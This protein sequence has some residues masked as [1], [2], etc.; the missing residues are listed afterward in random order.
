MTRLLLLSF[1]RVGKGTYWRALGFAQELVHL[2]YEVTLL[3]VAARRRWGFARQEINGVQVVESPDLMPRSGYDPWD[4]VNRL[5]WVRKRPFDLVHAFETRPVNI[6]PALLAQRRYK[7]PFVTDWCDWFGRGGSVEQRSNPLLRTILRPVETFFEEQFRPGAAG[8]TVINQT[9][10][11]KAHDLGIPAH[12]LLLLP[13]GANVTTI[14]PQDKTAVRAKLGLPAAAF[15]LGYTGAMFDDDALLM[16][17][18]FDQIQA[19]IP[20]ARLLLI[21]YTNVALEEMV[22][23][24]TAVW[25]TGPVNNQALADYVAAC[26]VGW[27]PLADIPA[28]QGRFPMKVHDFMAAGRPLLVSDL[29]DLGH[30][31]SQRNIGCAARSEPEAQA[32]QLMAMY[33]QPAALFT[34][35]VQARQTA[36]DEFAWSVVTAKL[37]RFYQQ[38]L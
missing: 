38:L 1:N 26:D 29:G 34:W 16:A 24:K 20:Q 31:V 21:G 15:V 12:G 35:G 32:Q 18:A 2:N 33:E 11:Q 14:R 9:L 19:A 22:R 28:N 3:A 8:T 27:L 25:R 36:T 6:F 7:V 17:A 5:A 37:D 30:F 10:W 23:E 4:V 13:N